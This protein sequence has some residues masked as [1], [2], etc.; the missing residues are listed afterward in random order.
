MDPNG[1]TTQKVLQDEEAYNAYWD[2][3]VIGRLKRC[4]PALAD[5]IIAVLTARAYGICR[6]N[7]SDGNQRG[8]G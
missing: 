5:K 1:A 8:T 7:L 3:I 6:G 4:G 2:R